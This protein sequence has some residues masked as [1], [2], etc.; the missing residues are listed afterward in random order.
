[1][2]SR[3]PTRIGR[4]ESL[5]S[6]IYQQIR[7][8]IHSGSIGRDDR[9]VDTEIAG[10]L[11][12]SRMP[13]REAL[14]RLTHEGYLVGTTRGFM[15][16]RLSATDIANIFE[17]RRL[18]EP[19]AAAHAA[20]DLD[21]AGIAALGAAAAEARIAAET[22]DAD[23]LYQANVAFRAGWLAAV[24]NDRLASAIA[25][26]AD[27]VQVVR[28][29]PLG[30]PPTQRLVADSLESLRDAFAAHDSVAASDRMTHFIARA[31]AA[32]AALSRS[33]DEAAAPTANEG[34]R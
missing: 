17:V 25:R 9:L 29:R 21:A 19:R 24:A 3:T 32:F 12:V 26:F 11:G 13:V 1:M 20:R 6:Q 16:P 2:D 8:R 23:R 31:E 27:H 30:D 7:H 10:R 14:L 33:D 34:R 5:R 28:Q 15:L 4:S 18:L 22:G